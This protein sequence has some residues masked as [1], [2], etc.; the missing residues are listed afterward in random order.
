MYTVAVLCNILLEKSAGSK[1]EVDKLN[2]E[3]WSLLQSLNE[4][5]MCQ[6]WCVRWCVREWVSIRTCLFITV[7]GW[8]DQRMQNTHWVIRTVSAFC[9]KCS[10]LKLWIYFTLWNVICFYYLSWKT[11]LMNILIVS[12][13]CWVCISLEIFR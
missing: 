7:N 13:L 11:F 4:Q 6:G 1:T 2:F 8:N 12:A 3:C 5:M 10:F 9:Y